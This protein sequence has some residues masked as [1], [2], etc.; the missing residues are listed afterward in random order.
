[1]LA[2]TLR[3]RKCSIVYN[4]EMQDVRM[5]SVHSIVYSVRLLYWV[6]YSRAQASYLIMW[7]WRTCAGEFRA[8][9]LGINSLHQL[10]FP[11]Y[12]T[13]SKTY[14]NIY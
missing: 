5:Y 1:M 12:L 9:S 14:I 6:T 10:T 2:K 13:L 3:S 11:L 7:A 8:L 4:E